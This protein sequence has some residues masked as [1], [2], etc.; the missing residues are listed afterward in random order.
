MRPESGALT[1]PVAPLLAVPACSKRIMQSRQ[2][3]PHPSKRQCT[4]P[5]PFRLQTDQRALDHCAEAHAA[6]AQ[7]AAAAVPPA[8]PPGGG[9]SARMTRS[10]A[11]GQGAA[12]T[13]PRPFCFATDARR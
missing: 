11:R 6:G 7:A 10:Q 2:S 8:A 4:E 1:A 5:E 9:D 12:L 13:H 3:P